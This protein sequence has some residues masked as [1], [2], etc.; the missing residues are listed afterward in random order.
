[1]AMGRGYGIATKNSQPWNSYPLKGPSQNNN[2]KPTIFS[3]FNISPFFLVHR[4]QRAIIFSPPDR[5]LWRVSAC[6]Y[7]YQPV[8]LLQASAL[9]GS[10]VDGVG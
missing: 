2:N 9:P 5:S 1:M 3:D 7:L 4:T 10:G 8:A 6:C